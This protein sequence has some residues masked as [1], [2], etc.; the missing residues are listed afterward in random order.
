MKRVRVLVANQPRLMRE[1]IMTTIADQ[2]DIELVG[3]VT[4]PKEIAEAVEH[5]RPDV[6]ILGMDK[7]GGSHEQC[8]FLLVRH[9]EMKILTL[10]P[11][12]NR[13]LVYWASVDVRNNPLESS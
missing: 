4:N 8:G 5:V 11:E 12:E 9:P 1:L 10:A 3:E 6:L 13:A 7:Q 2:A